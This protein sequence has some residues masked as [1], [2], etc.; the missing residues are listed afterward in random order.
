MP[1]GLWEDYIIILHNSLG[2]VLIDSISFILSCTENVLTDMQGKA[3]RCDKP[4]R[5]A[6]APW[7]RVDDFLLLIRM[8]NNDV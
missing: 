2:A 3:L 4:L 6:E 7:T 5:A 8:L 1:R